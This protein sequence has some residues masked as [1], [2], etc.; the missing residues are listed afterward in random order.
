MARGPARYAE[1]LILNKTHFLRK[2]FGSTRRVFFENALAQQDA[3]S[4]KTL[5]L[6]KT[7]FLRKRFGS[8]RHVFFENAFAKISASL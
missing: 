5:W 4:S 1:P 7:R 3:F 2:R 6:N 8:T